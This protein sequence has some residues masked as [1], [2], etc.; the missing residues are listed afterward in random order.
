M[1]SDTAKF[2]HGSFTDLYLLCSAA[3]EDRV[4]FIAECGA[5]SFDS[6]HYLADTGNELM[7][8]NQSARSKNVINDKVVLTQLVLDCTS[9]I[10][11]GKVSISPQESIVVGRI[12]RRLCF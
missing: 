3:E 5:S 11:A 10:V 9:A 4:N 12:T 7:H 8:S 1:Q 6:Q 2:K